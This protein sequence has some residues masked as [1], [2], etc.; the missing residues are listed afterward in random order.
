M[1][2]EAA[3]PGATPEGPAGSSIHATR[4]VPGSQNEATKNHNVEE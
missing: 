3:D 4:A 1:D 2:I